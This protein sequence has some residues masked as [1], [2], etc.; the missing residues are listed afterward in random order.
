MT[1]HDY[2][3]AIVVDRTPNEVFAAINDVRGWW[4]QD[5]EGS[6]DERG[7]EF[8]FRGHDI[9]RSQ[10]RVTELA[11]GERVEW[12]VVDNFINFVTDQS[13]WKNTRITFEIFAH[14][15]GTALR[16]R[17]VGL[18]PDYECYD[19]CSNAWAFFIN[20]SLRNLITTGV[21]APMLGNVVR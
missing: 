9:H 13:E 20:T 1:E 7:T 6:T 11:L 5:I 10:I 19:A 18:V 3:T 15:D 12:L 21:G 16:F 8:T 14:D 2:T 4:S 17:H